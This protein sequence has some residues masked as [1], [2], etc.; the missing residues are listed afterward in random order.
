MVALASACGHPA[1]QQL[2]TS[3]AGVRLLQLHADGSAAAAAKLL[4]TPSHAT[5]VLAPGDDC[6]YA[7]G[8]RLMFQGLVSSPMSIC[9]LSLEYCWASHRSLAPVLRRT[10]GRAVQSPEVFICRR[11]RLRALLAARSGSSL[12]GFAGGL[13]GAACA[14]AS[15]RRRQRWRCAAPVA[16]VSAAAAAGGAP[17][18]RP[19]RR[20]GP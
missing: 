20:L 12:H 18:R 16:G 11:G 7:G 15:W 19:H 4:P 17:R 8:E 6:I 14:A 13:A 2:D 3:A 5:C 10:K 1:S 9:T